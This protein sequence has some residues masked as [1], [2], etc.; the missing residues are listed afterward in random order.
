MPRPSVPG[1][2]E[3]SEGLLKAMRKRLKAKKKAAN[4]APQTPEPPAPGVLAPTQSEQ[5]E[6]E[7]WEQRQQSSEQLPADEEV[8]TPGPLP[9][10]LL[11]SSRKAPLSSHGASKKK[12]Q[13][14]STPVNMKRDHAAWRA[15]L[16]NMS[17]ELGRA[18]EEEKEKAKVSRAA[19]NKTLATASP[20]P[21]GNKLVTTALPEWV[22]GREDLA[23]GTFFF[24]DKDLDEGG[25]FAARKE[26]ANWEAMVVNLDR[27]PDRMQSFENAVHGSQQWLE[28]KICRIRA[29]DG[30]LVL[31]NSSLEQ[32]L[33]SKGWLDSR[34]WQQGLLHT[35]GRGAASWSDL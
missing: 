20:P 1:K 6:R 27:R 22:G 11:R 31:Q 7:Q 16:R 18:V 17:T 14:T 35:K 24:N 19:L 3:D 33:I 13:Q 15:K 34:T 21:A 25:L 12:V 26:D 28:E 23:P 9:K 10:P 5:L 32:H 4:G 29:L 2:A 8:P 30:K